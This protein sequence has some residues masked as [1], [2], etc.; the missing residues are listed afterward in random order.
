MLSAIA[1]LASLFT[2]IQ[3]AKK[4]PRS[5]FYWIFCETPRKFGFSDNLRLVSLVKAYSNK[6]DSK[7]L[8]FKEEFNCLWMTFHLVT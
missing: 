1:L 8:L 3:A 4:Q 2:A 6:I 5:Y 7:N